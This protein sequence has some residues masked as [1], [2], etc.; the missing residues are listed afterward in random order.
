MWREV[1]VILIDLQCS[2]IQR[3]VKNAAKEG[4]PINIEANEG[5]QSTSRLS[6]LANQNDAQGASEVHGAEVSSI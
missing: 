5:I 6:R 1:I 2:K 4:F 3:E